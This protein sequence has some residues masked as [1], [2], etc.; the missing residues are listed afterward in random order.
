MSQ[1]TKGPWRK[2]LIDSGMSNGMPIAAEIYPP[3]PLTGPLIAYVNS[4]EADADLIEAAPDL[5]AALQEIRDMPSPAVDAANVALR[6][7]AVAAAAIAKA[8]S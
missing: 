6:M 5:L 2:E 3:L 1:H 4:S 7:R 8:Q